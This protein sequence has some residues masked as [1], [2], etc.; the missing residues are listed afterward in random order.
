MASS[1]PVSWRG[2]EPQLRTVLKMLHLRKYTNVTPL[3]QGSEDALLVCS[4]RH[5]AGATLVQVYFLSERKVG[6]KT[7][8]KI[9]QECEA[10]S[11]QH[12]ILV[13]EEGLTPFA[14]KEVEDTEK[15]PAGFVTEV[16]KKKE[17]CFCIM[18]HSLVP[19][20]TLLSACEKK[21]LLQKLSCKTSALPKIKET[22]PVCKFMH[23]QAGSVLRIDR[24][25][26][27]CPEVYYRLV[28]Q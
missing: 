27:S 1:S 7:F 15:F 25:I 6:V 22:D 14:S 12:L 2:W 10:M 24:Q 26:G 9:S 13:T 4:A 21:E 16:F 20:H 23:F 19:P 17:L 5:Y 18:E 3:M 8:R 28:C 11:C